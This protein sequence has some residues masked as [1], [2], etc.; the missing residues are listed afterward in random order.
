MAFGW[1]VVRFVRS[2]AIVLADEG[3]TVGIG[4]GQMSRVDSV[5]LALEKARQADLD[6]AGS[7]LA[8]DGFF[9]FP[10]SIEAAHAAGIRAVIEPGGSIRDQAVIDRADELDMT[11][12]FTGTRH[13]KH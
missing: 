3:A 7:A 1:A 9:P 8:S 13:F 6:P 10:D 12:V 11:L 2:N 5:D 4:A